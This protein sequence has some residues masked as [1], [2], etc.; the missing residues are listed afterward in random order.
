M[1]DGVPFLLCLSG[2]GPKAINLGGSGGQSPPAQSPDVVDVVDFVRRVRV[3]LV[4]D[5]G[6]EIMVHCLRVRSQSFFSPGILSPA[7]QVDSRT[8][9]HPRSIPSWIRRRVK[10]QA[11]VRRSM[12]AGTDEFSCD[13]PAGQGR[14][15]QVDVGSRGR[16]LNTTV[17]IQGLPQ[18]G[19]DRGGRTPC[20]AL[21]M[22]P[23]SF[24]CRADVLGS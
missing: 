15:N 9:L 18:T 11:V 16:V 7:R 5:V 6:F 19:T 22:Q 10:F 13:H 20:G 23:F 2:I 14:L 21:P 4:G 3:G 12:N 24:A 1:P 17:P 8:R